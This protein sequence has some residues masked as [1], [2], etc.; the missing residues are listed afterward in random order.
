MHGS[1]VFLF[2]KSTWFVSFVPIT[3]CLLCVGCLALNNTCKA[4]ATGTC[5]TLRTA[6][7]FVFVC[8][9]VGVRVSSA[10]GA[11]LCLQQPKTGEKAER[12][13]SVPGPLPSLLSP[14]QQGNCD[15]RGRLQRQWAL[16]WDDICSFIG[17]GE[18]GGGHLHLPLIHPLTAFTYIQVVWMLNKVKRCVSEHHHPPPQAGQTELLRKSWRYKHQS[19]SSSVEYFGSWLKWVTKLHL[20]T[21]PFFFLDI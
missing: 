19:S 7:Q 8:V 2:F 9:D 21:W 18:G 6:I 5:F 15:T 14:K 3:I 20:S 12:G 13:R 4:K 16:R 17:R 1:C 10:A 11:R